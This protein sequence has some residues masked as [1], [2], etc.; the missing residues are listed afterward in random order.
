MTRYVAFL[1]AVNLGRRRVSM[2]T[3]KAALEELGYD[4]VG[5][6]VNSGNL[7]FTTTGAR[8]AVGHEATIRARL[9]DEYGFEITT[10]V[11]TAKQVRSLATDKPFGPI[12]A[13]HTHFALLP[14][15]A[16]TTTEKKAVEAMS[17]DHDECVVIGGDVHWLIRSKSTDTTLGPK[18]W[19]DA[20]PGNPTTARNTTMLAKLVAKL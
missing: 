1:R 15:T 5:S 19:R 20:L 6:W 7:L 3:C 18:Q 13:G 8:R 14:L 12:T 11:R 9:E 17:N 4:D 10:F 2:A 16:L